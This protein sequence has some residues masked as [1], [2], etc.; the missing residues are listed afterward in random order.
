MI[1]P[2]A[3]GRISLNPIDHL[4]P[5]GTIMMVVSSLSGFGIGWGKPVPDQPVQLPASEMGQP[6]G[7][8]VGTA[9]E[10][11]YGG[12]RRARCSGSAAIVIDASPVVLQRPDAAAGDH[13]GEHRAGAVQPDPDPAA[14]RLA[15][16]LGAAAL[17]AA[18]GNMSMFMARYG[19][20]VFL[21]LIS[22]RRSTCSD[23]YSV[24]PRE[25]LLAAVLRDVMLTGYEQTK[26]AFG[27]AADGAAASGQ[28]RGRAGEL[29][30]ASG[31]V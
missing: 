8:A 16:T 17:R 11:A 15:H 14:G 25:F 28:S 3:Q 31:R 24:P 18:R 22:L 12:G 2:S 9:V 10:P 29:G 27:D 26:T 20:L 21:G 30:R 5:M 13:D 19:M 6:E 4:D 1:P 7:V 23:A